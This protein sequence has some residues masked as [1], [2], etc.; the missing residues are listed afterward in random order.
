MW[1]T[2]FRNAKKQITAFTS[3]FCDL[4][5]TDYLS[6]SQIPSST[7]MTISGYQMA[8]P[9]RITDIEYVSVKGDQFLRAPW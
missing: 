7:I 8:F 6:E 2:D 9:L 4:I 5:R 3:I 1:E